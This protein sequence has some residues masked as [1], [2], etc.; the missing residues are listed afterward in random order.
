MP[1]NN[2][3]PLEDRPRRFTIVFIWPVLQFPSDSNQ[4]ARC[5]GLKGC[6]YPKL[7]LG[8]MLRIGPVG[9]SSDTMDSI[10]HVGVYEISISLKRVGT[11]RKDGWESSITSEKM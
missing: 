6:G 7:A 4:N 10:L 9:E 1:D 2:Q 5:P 11:K 3:N 8:Q